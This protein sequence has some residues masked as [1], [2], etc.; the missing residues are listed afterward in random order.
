MTIFQFSFTPNFIL[1]TKTVQLN[2]SKFRRFRARLSLL[3]L[4]AVLRKS[5]LYA[6]NFVKKMCTI[7]SGLDQAMNTMNTMQN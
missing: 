3:V 5:V 6:N 7:P 4:R 2:F 1:S